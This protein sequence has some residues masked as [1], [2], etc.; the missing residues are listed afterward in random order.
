MLTYN[1]QNIGRC[2]ISAAKT[3]LQTQPNDLGCLLLHLFLVFLQ[4]NKFTMPTQSYFNLSNHLSLSDIA[5]G[6]CTSPQIIRITL[7]QSKLIS[8]DKE[9]IYT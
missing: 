8:F 3:P 6:S 5:L 2:T 1:L 9:R 4:V 7:K